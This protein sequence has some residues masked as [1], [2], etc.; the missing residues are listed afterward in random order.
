MKLASK[1]PRLGSVG[2]KQG[3]LHV[4][5]ADGGVCLVGPNTDRETELTPE[6]AR[7]L[8]TLLQCA[9]DRA[10]ESLVFQLL[11]GTPTAEIVALLRGTPTAESIAL[12]A[13][14]ERMREERSR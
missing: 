6:A 3:E 9:A 13:A 4:H 10:M 8:A 12:A 2:S 5:M 1:V 7:A 11:R 14:I